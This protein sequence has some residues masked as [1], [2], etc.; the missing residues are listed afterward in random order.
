MFGFVKPF[1]PNLRVKEYE[2]YKSVYCGL[3]R[4]MKKHTGGIS[5][6]TL[7]YDMTFFALVRL[8]LTGEDV[9]IQKKRCAV[10]PMKARPMMRDNAALEYSAYVS[11]LLVWYKL[12]DTIADEH[13]IKRIGAMTVMPCASGMKRNC[14][15]AGEEIGN[16]VRGAMENIAA[17]EKEKCPTPDMPA[18]VFGKMLGALL[19]WGL[20]EKEAAIAEEIGLHT[21]RWVYLAD[22]VC[23]YDN[24][25]K[26]GSY[27]PFLYALPDEDQ[28]LDFKRN[29]LHGVFSME[30]EAIMRAV[31]L[32][33]F[34]DQ[35]LL[36][37]CIENIIDYGMESALSIA[38][39]KEE[40]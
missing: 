2:Y 30:T 7:S 38:L 4:S 28:M 11:G 1:I 36:S 21:G 32:I 24:D 22:A 20:E 14:S 29:M 16:I 18:D 9:L 3:C 19:A 10:H 39:G 40:T 26:N 31:N 33:D 34:G 12:Q 15:R 17:L 8:A 27:N 37:R 13:G 35:L 23:D 25:R 6:A 5:R